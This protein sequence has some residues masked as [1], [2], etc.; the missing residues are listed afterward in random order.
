MRE[1][2]G[3]NVNTED[4]REKY[5]SLNNQLCTVIDMTK[6]NWWREQR[7]ELQ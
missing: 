6:D 4:G 5:K 3:K 2:S 1:G 7:E